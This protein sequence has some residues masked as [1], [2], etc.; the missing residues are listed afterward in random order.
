MKQP[1]NVIRMPKDVSENFNLLRNYVIKSVR[2]NAC[3]LF[4][5]NFEIE[6]HTAP[7]QSF[8]A[9]G[10]VHGMGNI[11]IQEHIIVFR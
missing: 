10:S 5:T 11:E 7:R 4:V 8:F 1:L 9:W 3:M 6:M 2:Y